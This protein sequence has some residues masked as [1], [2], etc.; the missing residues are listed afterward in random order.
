MS[1]SYPH[2]LETGFGLDEASAAEMQRA[3]A[4][5]K[6]E[7]AQLVADQRQ[8]KQQRIALEQLKTTLDTRQQELHQA[9][10]SLQHERQTSADHKSSFETDLDARHDKLRADQQVLDAQVADLQQRQQQQLAGQQDLETQ[11]RGLDSRQHELD[12]R[13]KDL[14]ARE[15]ALQSQ[16]KANA[17]HKA[18]L[19]RA[20]ADLQARS[21]KLAEQIAQRDL[22]AKDISG[23][24]EQ[25]QQREQALQ[26]Q[27]AELARLQQQLIQQEAQL[28]ERGIALDAQQEGL[29][30]QVERLQ[31]DD[32]RLREEM[33]LLGQQRRAAESQQQAAAQQRETLNRLQADLS[34]REASLRKKEAELSALQGRLDAA[35]AKQRNEPPQRD[36][37]AAASAEQLQL[38]SKRFEGVQAEVAVLREQKQNL[39][40]ERDKIGQECA[41]LEQ[42]CRSL[43]SLVDE[44]MAGRQTKAREPAAAPPQSTT[45]P[46][47]TIAAHAARTRR[48]LRTAVVPAGAIRLGGLTI[49][50]VV[51]GAAALLAAVVMLAVRPGVYRLDAR[52][53]LPA[54]SA[55]A[56]RGE[57]VKAQRELGGRLLEADL[58][59]GQAAADCLP[60]ALDTDRKSLAVQV[61]S[62]TPDRTAEI[63]KSLL[64][65][66]RTDLQGQMLAAAQTKMAA[67]LAR[68]ITMYQEQLKD[69]STRRADLQGKARSL[70]PR[71]KVYAEAL[72]AADKARKDLDDLRA[73]SDKVSAALR[74]LL[75]TPPASKSDVPAEQL[76]MEAARDSQLVAVRGQV[77]VRGAE[78]RDMLAQLVRKASDKCGEM[79][80]H[81]AKFVA[82]LDSQSKQVPDQA[83]QAEIRRIAEPSAKMR[84][85][86][87]DSQ[88]QIEELSAS[89][90]KAQEVS[91]VRRLVDLHAESEKAL[92]LLISQADGA[93]KAIDALLE[94]IPAGGEDVT[95][96]TV[97]QQRLRA[98]FALIQKTHQEMA[99]TLSSLRPSVNF[100]LDAALSGVEGLA[101]QLDQRQKGLIEQIQQQDAR[102]QRIKYDKQVQ[103][104]RGE[105]DDYN[106]ERDRVLAVLT[107]TSDRMLQADADRAQLLQ[108]RGTMADLDRQTA[109]LNDTLSAARKRSDNLQAA[110][111]QPAP[112]TLEGPEKL[113]PAVNARSR[114]ISAVVAAVAVF[115]VVLAV[116][117]LAIPTH[118]RP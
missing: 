21:D 25:L 95:R 101:R 69:L 4:R 90:G 8:I 6:Q 10:Q 115:A 26:Q 2:H 109:A 84:Q 7:Q 85:V 3:I 96:R 98:Q 16:Q 87:R 118:R 104:A 19:D 75:R 57:L 76:E 117:M 38:L 42:R 112:I 108:L 54:G 82:F 66:Y 46:L 100:R 63:L 30:R 81:L 53:V 29:R 11:A 36:V 17:E 67:D 47:A 71:E 64:A 70:E 113:E 105:L 43:Q 78:L 50:A 55:L 12:A 24:R 52:I 97:L 34:A 68:Q 44:L 91:Q 62:A 48:Q 114:M 88:R 5:L 41:S 33:D 93:I 80:G 61:L 106:V 65:R 56:E 37:Q 107:A 86:V 31:A 15:A 18:S 13:Y 28:R 102:Q 99:E 45:D 60:V 51:A 9:L 92:D 72:A 111:S 23:A 32:K 79:D 89:I 110:A 59:G 22:V 35:T 39:A 49:P 103:D 83:L 58:L 1:E 20:A 14:E 40:R 94:K 27:A 77:A 74:V 116:Y 73:R